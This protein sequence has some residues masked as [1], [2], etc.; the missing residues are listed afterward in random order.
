MPRNRG[1]PSK[2]ADSRC[3]SSACTRGDCGPTGGLDCRGADSEAERQLQL[4][5]I[6]ASLQGIDADVFGLTEIQNDT[7]AAT[8]QTPAGERT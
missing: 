7:G 6:V 1:A 4:A 2:P 8:Q 5:K 3:I